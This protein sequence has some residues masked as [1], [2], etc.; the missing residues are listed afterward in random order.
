MGVNAITAEKTVVLFE[1]RCWNCRRL[2]MK[3]ARGSTGEMQ[4]KCRNCN[5]MNELK[6]ERTA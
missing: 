6:L 1:W 5:A 2:I 4:C 3:Y